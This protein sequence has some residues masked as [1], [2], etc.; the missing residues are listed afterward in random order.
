MIQYQE[1]VSNHDDKCR[2]DG[3]HYLRWIDASERRCGVCGKRFD[4][5]GH[6]A[7]HPDWGTNRNC[8]CNVCTH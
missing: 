7:C 4:M 5:V 2:C 1:S 8:E 3:C 6:C